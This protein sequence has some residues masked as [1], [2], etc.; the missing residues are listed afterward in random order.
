[1]SGTSVLSAR[2]RKAGFVRSRSAGQTT[3]T[4]PPGC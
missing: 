3:S 1:M 2:G 4:R